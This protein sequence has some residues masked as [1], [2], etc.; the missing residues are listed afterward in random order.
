VKRRRLFIIIIGVLAAVILVIT[1]WPNEREPEYNG[2]TLSKWL[3]RYNGVKKAEATE[4]IRH[5]GTN[6][7]PFLV[8]WIQH[9]TPNWRYSLQRATSKLPAAIQDARCVQWLLIDKAGRR[10]DRAVDGFEI[11]GEGAEPAWSELVNLFEDD[12]AEETARRAW[13]CMASIGMRIPPGDFD[14]RTVL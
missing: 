5:I 10:A 8:R 13:I 14:K 1:L 6:A 11:L 4:A 2:V 12:K 3:E 7:L 9:E